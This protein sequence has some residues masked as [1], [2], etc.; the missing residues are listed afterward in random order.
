MS[1]IDHLQKQQQE[2]DRRL[3]KALDD[4]GRS[5]LGMPTSVETFKAWLTQAGLCLVPKSRGEAN[6]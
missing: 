2:V 3:H 5:A 4:A 6:G 1:L